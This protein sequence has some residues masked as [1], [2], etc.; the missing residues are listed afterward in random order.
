M[1]KATAVLFAFA[2][3]TATAVVAHADATY[4]LLPYCQAWTDTTKVTANDNWSTVPGIVGYR[5]DDLTTLTGVD[6][7]TLVADAGPGGLV[8]DVNPNRS[9]PNVFI[10]GGVTEFDGPLGFDPV[11]AMQGSGTSDAPALVLHLN[12]SGLINIRIQY[13]LRDIDGSADNAQ[14]QFALQYRTGGGTGNYTNVP[15]G[16]VADASTGGTATQV[17]PVNVLLPFACENQAQLQ[18]RIMTTN[19]AGSDEWVGVDDICVTGDPVT[20]VEPTTWGAVKAL[21]R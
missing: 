5:G 6:P 10:T 19:A 14:Q 1:K 11:V 18:L 21:Y 13:N 15:A 2:A 4:Q 8:V 7:Q 9:D 16:Y 17:T 20:P 12:T 3:V